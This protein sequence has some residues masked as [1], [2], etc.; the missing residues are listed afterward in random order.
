MDRREAS[1]IPA[2]VLNR[3]VECIL[4]RPPWTEEKLPYI[5]WIRLPMDEATR[6]RIRDGK[7]WSKKTICASCG[8]PIPVPP[9]RHGSRVDKTRPSPCPRCHKEANPRARPR[10]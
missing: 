1:P 10:H 8:R 7:P 4:A 6:Y 2:S 9:R 3:E 5:K